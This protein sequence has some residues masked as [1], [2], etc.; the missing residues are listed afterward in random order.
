MNQRIP[1]R[2]REAYLK[3]MQYFRASAD[4]LTDRFGKEAGDMLIEAIEETERLIKEIQVDGES[5]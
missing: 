4:R 1:A 5:A 2:E 3:S